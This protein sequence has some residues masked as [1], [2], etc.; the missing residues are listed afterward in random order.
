ME[1]IDNSKKG[2]RIIDV[3]TLETYK[4]DSGAEIVVGG[5]DESIDENVCIDENLFTPCALT[6]ATWVTNSNIWKEQGKRRYSAIYY[7]KVGGNIRGKI[8]VTNHYTI[9]KSS[10]T[11][12]SPAIWEYYYETP[13]EITIKKDAYKSSRKELTQKG[14]QFWAGAQYYVTSLKKQI[15][16]WRPV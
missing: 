11:M 15:H 1:L 9:N 10:I 7:L 14:H 5:I 12:R 4:L 6:K 3:T 2:G 16:L 8:T 13:L